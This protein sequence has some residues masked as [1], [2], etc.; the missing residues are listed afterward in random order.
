MLKDHKDEMIVMLKRKNA[1]QEEQL[2]TLGKQ[3]EDM[4]K[5]DTAAESKIKA[6][7]EMHSQKIRTLLKS[8]QSLKKE[9]QREKFEKKD[10]VRG[11]MIE[12]LKKDIELQELAINAL[13]KLVNS[14]DKCDLAIKQELDKGPKRIRVASREELKMDINKYKNMTLRLLDVLKQNGIKSPAGIK[15][16]VSTVGAG[17][18]EEKTAGAFDINNM[19]AANSQAGD[20]E[21]ENGD[22][23]FNDQELLEAKER[24]EEQ[25]V[26]LNMEVKDKNEK[27]LELLDEMEEIKIQ[28]YARD[29]SI[30]LQQK[31]IENLLEELRDS[32]SMD[33]DIKV[34]VSKKIALEEENQRM[35]KELDERFVQQHENQFEQNEMSL[36]NKS[37]VD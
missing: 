32:K 34:L 7:T 2:K 1:E 24:L 4:K 18:K 31:Q 25:V 21:K 9:V 17:L 28:V 22:L 13:R 26:K 20:N 35:K 12:R 37:L 10:N 3:N 11:Q 19:S 29:K 30:E 8:I 5:G 33:N 27:I 16:E 6:L 15:V 14:E 23:G 36:E